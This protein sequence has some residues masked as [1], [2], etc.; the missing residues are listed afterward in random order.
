MDF[1]I[2]GL[3]ILAVLFLARQIGKAYDEMSK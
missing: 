1:V 3:L 2:V